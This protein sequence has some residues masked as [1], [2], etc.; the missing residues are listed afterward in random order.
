MKKIRCFLCRFKRESVIFGILCTYRCVIT[1]PRWKTSFGFRQ[2]GPLLD[3]TPRVIITVII[4]LRYRFIYIYRSRIVEPQT[5][6]GRAGSGSRIRAY[7]HTP[8]S[9]YALCIYLYTC[10]CAHKRCTI[11]IRRRMTYPCL[12]NMCTSTNVYL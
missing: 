3:I 2:T 10:T 7:R 11:F 5:F 12:I 9:V 6:H 4:I 1:T 8:R